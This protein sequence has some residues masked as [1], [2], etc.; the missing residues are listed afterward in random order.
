MKK[1]KRQLY[2][3]GI[4]CIIS[5]QSIIGQSSYIFHHLET[6]DGLSNNTV[7]A[8]LRDS[9]GF[10]WIG[11]EAGLNRYDGNGFNVYTTRF[12]I[13][14]SLVTN[15]II[16][17]QEDGLGNIWVY[18]GYTYMVYDRDKDCFNPDIKQLLHNLGIQSEDNSRVFVDRKRNI[19]V[20][21]KRKAFFYDVLKKTTAIF[22]VE[23]PSTE[24]IAANITDD[25]EN[26]YTILK[27]G[28]CWQMNK[29]TGVQTL[30]QLPDFIKPEIAN[31]RNKV[32]ADSN[33][34]LWFSSSLSDQIL[35]KKS[36][37]KEWEIINLTSEIKSVSNV[38]TS[39][40]ETQ[41]G[42]IWIGTDHKGIFIY[43]KVKN[44][45]TNIVNKPSTNTS[46]SSNSVQSLYRDNNGTIWIGHN[47][48]GSR[49]IMIVFA[50]LLI[51]N[52]LNV[53]ILRR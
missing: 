9:Y 6:K 30:I 18:F 15:D 19:W 29:I 53:Q 45:I 20:L 12:G 38:I 3:L 16:D 50:I 34:G 21:N 31:G 17:L 46:L 48:K 1:H 47:K 11:T 44:I 35:Y 27:P 13:L 49:F 33:N 37:S 8:F 26:L 7:K 41:T 14:K 4:L 51:F 2:M 24:A 43:D 5:F 10:L 25:G 23:I 22:N 28:V 40:I 52:I 36:L 32:Y 39:I 42:Q